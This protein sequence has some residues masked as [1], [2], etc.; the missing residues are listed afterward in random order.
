[1]NKIKGNYEEQEDFEKQR[2]EQINTMINNYRHFKMDNR[3]IDI[4]P[5]SKSK[6]NSIK[7]TIIKG[8]TN[9]LKRKEKNL[10][11]K[12][13]DFDE[14]EKNIFEKTK[15]QNKNGINI[16]EIN[17]RLKKKNDI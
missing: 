8:K 3:R 1:M 13:N 16:V 14:I 5:N 15:A 4:Y 7:E 9:D 12:R 6:N 11:L 2:N 17:N 10:F